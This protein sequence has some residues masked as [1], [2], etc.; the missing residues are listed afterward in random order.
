M[1]LVLYLRSRVLIL[2][3]GIKRAM[4]NKQNLINMIHGVENKSS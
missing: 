1:K 2:L 3:Y 4:H